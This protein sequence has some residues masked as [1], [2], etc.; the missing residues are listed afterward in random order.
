MRAAVTSLLALAFC[1]VPV[2]AAGPTVTLDYTNAGLTPGH[3]LLTVS[4]DGTGHFKSERGTAAADTSKGFEAADIDRDIKVSADFASH[5]FTAARQRSLFNLPC[6][7]H[8]K[9]AFQGAKKLS[10]DGPEGAG[11][12]T[13]NFSK[14]K[15]IQNLGESLMAVATAVIEGARLE[16]L[17]QHDRLGL[18]REMEYLAEA[19]GDG[20]VQQIGTIRETLERLSEDPQVMDRV[21]KRARMLLAKAGG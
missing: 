12:C 2:W 3:W 21:R 13:F 15:E 17:L 16:T 5:A 7:S 19:A 4:E 8:M 6:E 20:R 9:V 1:C 10:Y 11:T 14:D 18:D